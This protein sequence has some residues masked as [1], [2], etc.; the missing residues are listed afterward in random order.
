MGCSFATDRLCDLGLFLLS[1][2]GPVLAF[3]VVLRS[4]FPLGSVGG[5]VAERV[6]SP[7]AL[8][9]QVQG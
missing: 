3:H 9:A 8:S 6:E 2:G 7:S 5:W 4:W 1:L